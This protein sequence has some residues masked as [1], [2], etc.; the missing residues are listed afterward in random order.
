MTDIK[1]SHSI[2]NIVSPSKPDPVNEEAPLSSSKDE[3]YD[4]DKFPPDIKL[5]E[6]HGVMIVILLNIFL[7]S[8]LV[9]DASR[10]LESRRYMC[11]LWIKR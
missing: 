11:L 4:P 9:C 3:H 5:A 2:N 1:K 10:R 6:K 8:L 7:V